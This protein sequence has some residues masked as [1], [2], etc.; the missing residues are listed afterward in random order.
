MDSARAV[1]KILVESDPSAPKSARIAAQALV[2][3]LRFE[4]LV[5]FGP[6]D[7]QGNAMTGMF[8]G[9]ALEGAAI[10]LTFG[11]K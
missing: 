8:A 3:A 11:S 9:Q 6:I 10:R 4:K 5:V 7:T 2:D 1:E